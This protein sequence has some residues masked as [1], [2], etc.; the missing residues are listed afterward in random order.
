MINVMNITPEEAEIHK[1]LLNDESYQWSSAMRALGHKNPQNTK[2]RFAN[3]IR[4]WRYKGIIK[5]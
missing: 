5:N 4:Y 1:R 2:Q 3:V